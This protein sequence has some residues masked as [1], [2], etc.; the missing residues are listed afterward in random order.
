MNV[1]TLNALVLHCGTFTQ[2]NDLNLDYAGCVIG[3]R[4][5]TGQE[6]DDSQDFL[7]ILR[8]KVQIPLTLKKCL[9]NQRVCETFRILKMILCLVLFIYLNSDVGNCS[10]INSKKRNF[11]V[12]SNCLV[13]F[14]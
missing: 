9:T 1:N 6:M 13:K 8:P 10:L 14:S 5:Q 12:A 2:V 3:L 4:A 7:E 11:V